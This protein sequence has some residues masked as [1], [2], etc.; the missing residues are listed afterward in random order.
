MLLAGP[1][2]YKPERRPPRTSSIITI[3]MLDH[4]TKA[5]G[6]LGH[7]KR[8][9]QK[10]VKPTKMNGTLLLK[11]L[12]AFCMLDNVGAATEPWSAELVAMDKRYTARH[13]A[14]EASV[15]ALR[16]EL[17]EQFQDVRQCSGCMSPSPPPPSPSPPPPSP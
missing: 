12:S 11:L 6:L 14:C 2:A 5:Y 8:S 4:M 10:K 1:F 16:S 3:P 9:P 17:Y 13:D 7:G 15:T